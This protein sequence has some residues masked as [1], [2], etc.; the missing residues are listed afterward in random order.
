MS[1]NPDRH[2]YT[3]SADWLRSIG[4]ASSRAEAAGLKAK[5][6]KEIGEDELWVASV[7]SEAYQ[8]TELGAVFSEAE[9]T[10]R[11]FAEKDPDVLLESIRRAV[12]STLGNREAEGDLL[13]PAVA[14]IHRTLMARCP[15]EVHLDRM[16]EKLLPDLVSLAMV[17]YA[18]LKADP[19]MPERAHP[20]VAAFWPL[21]AEELEERRRKRVEESA[22]RY[23]FER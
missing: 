16:Q 11:H 18:L 20:A 19:S 2:P 21:V 14:Q 15:S 23:S 17:G 6:A 4:A 9:Q 13:A 1:F 22:L 5:I 12:G 10:P 3:Y 8:L 7:F